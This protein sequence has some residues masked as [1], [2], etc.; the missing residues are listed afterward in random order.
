MYMNNSNQRVLKVQRAMLW[1]RLE[2]LA[3]CTTH[4]YTCTIHVV[5]QEL[6]C[7]YYIQEAR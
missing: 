2:T 7:K 4:V 3:E 1:F 5:D 6:H